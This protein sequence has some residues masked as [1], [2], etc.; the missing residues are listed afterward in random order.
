[1]PE[2]ERVPG[3]EEST[4]PNGVKVPHGD[5]GVTQGAVVDSLKKRA[6]NG[7]VDAANRATNNARAEVAA[8]DAGISADDVK[9]G[10]ENESDKAAEGDGSA[11]GDTVDTV[12]ESSSGDTKEGEGEGEVE[13]EG[14]GDGE[15]GAGVEDEGGEAASAFLQALAGRSERAQ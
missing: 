15:G 1:M 3:Q 8:A 12:A 6:I 11:A 14:E 7:A 2:D 4:L 5:A 10:M 13:G 9:Q